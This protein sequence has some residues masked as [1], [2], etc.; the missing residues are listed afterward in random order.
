MIT[1]QK[2]IGNGYF[3]RVIDEFTSHEQESL[4]V[5]WQELATLSKLIVDEYYK[6]HKG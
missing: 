2:G 6:N 1:L 5:T 4:A 3:I